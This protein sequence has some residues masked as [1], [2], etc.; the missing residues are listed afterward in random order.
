MERLSNGNFKYRVY[1]YSNG[2][3][4]CIITKSQMLAFRKEYHNKGKFISSIHSFQ[5]YVET[6]LAYNN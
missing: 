1:G 6:V 2:F 5:D 4:T 3:V